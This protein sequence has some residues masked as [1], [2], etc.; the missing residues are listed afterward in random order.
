[1]QFLKRHKTKN[2]VKLIPNLL[3][4]K[5]SSLI[6]RK[7]RLIIYVCF[8]FMI[9][10]FYSLEEITPAE[11]REKVLRKNVKFPIVCPMFGAIFILRWTQN[12]YVKTCKWTFFF[13]IS[14]TLQIW[15]LPIVIKSIFVL[16]N[17]VSLVV[18]M[19]AW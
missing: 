1:M 11:G 8:G 10:I 14:L 7:I 9:L 18:Y 5:K 16:K 15:S 6:L 2:F 17:I 3:F 12:F 4:W 13:Y 19:F